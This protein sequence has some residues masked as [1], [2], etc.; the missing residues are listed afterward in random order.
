[1]TYTFPKDFSEPVLAL[2]ALGEDPA[3][4]REWMKYTD[5]GVN[6]EHIPELI[7]IVNEIEIFMP[8]DADADI[9]GAPEI[10]APIHAWRALG[11]LKAEEAIP[12]L[13][14]L[15]ISN[16]D[17]DID[18]IMEEMP[19][20]MAL[21]GPACIPPLREYLLNP[22]KLEWASATCSS[23]LEK[24]GLEHPESRA[25]CVKALEEALENYA[26]NEP[27]VNGSIIASLTDLNASESAPIVKRAFDADLVDLMIMGDYEDYQVEV[28][29]I[30]KRKT[31]ARNY[32]E[33][34]FHMREKIQDVIENIRMKEQIA[35]FYALVDPEIK[36]GKLG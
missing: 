2:C 8:E 17:L 35:D 20:T 23:A 12:T 9:Q 31:P 15:I 3:R 18:W 14:D 1:M 22:K 34:K 28:G 16:D 5:L 10:Y 30:E 33:E 29:L 32:I 7:R 26:D 24:M 13:M 4:T 36:K 27:G 21:I 25:D 19:E 11:Q 6:E